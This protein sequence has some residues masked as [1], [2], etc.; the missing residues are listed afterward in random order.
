MGSGHRCA[1]DSVD[2][3]AGPGGCDVRSGGKNV[4]EGSVVR[5]GRP[6]ITDIC[7][8]DGDR[9][10][11]TRRACHGSVLI[12]ISLRIVQRNASIQ[13]RHDNLQRPRCS[14]C[15]LK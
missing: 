7:C 12:R 13:S 14:V 1:R 6:A 9:V 3:A 2:P 5:V 4:N 10:W 15:H 11:G 8:A